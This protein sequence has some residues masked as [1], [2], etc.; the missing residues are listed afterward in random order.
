MATTSQAHPRILSSPLGNWS[1][2]LHHLS[3]QSSQVHPSTEARAACL[4]CMRFTSHHEWLQTTPTKTTIL[5]AHD[6]RPGMQCLCSSFACFASELNLRQALHQLTI[7]GQAE[8][9]LHASI[10]GALWVQQHITTFNVLAFMS[11]LSCGT[12]LVVQFICELAGALI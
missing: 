11:D 3:M 6:A 12:L 4:P 2:D 10:T 1:S 8:S 9:L 7:R 5:A